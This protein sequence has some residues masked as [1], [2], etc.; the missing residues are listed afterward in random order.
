MNDTELFL[1]LPKEVAENEVTDLFN[2]DSAATP[3]R[4]TQ[5]YRISYDTNLSQDLNKPE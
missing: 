3:Y 1:N 4:T 2:Y 5:F